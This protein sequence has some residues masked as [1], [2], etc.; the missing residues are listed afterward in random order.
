MKLYTF[1]C[2]KKT[3]I[4]VMMLALPSRLLRA[5][6]TAFMFSSVPIWHLKVH[7]LPSSFRGLL[8]KKIFKNLCH[9]WVRQRPCGIL[10]RHARPAGISQDELGCA[11]LINKP[12]NRWLVN[13]KG[14]FP[15]A[16]CLVQVS[17]GARP[18]ISPQRK[19]ATAFTVCMVVGC[20]GRG[21]REHGRSFIFFQGE[22]HTAI[23]LAKASLRTTLNLKEAGL[24]RSWR[25]GHWNRGDQPPILPTATPHHTGIC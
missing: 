18:W 25:K 14:W 4:P 6:F 2:Q 12:Q 15:H 20:H 13:N 10:H 21:R 8:F 11:A 7:S 5:E 23:P 9:L 16:S 24:P 22:H 3:S 19:P 17:W 1:S